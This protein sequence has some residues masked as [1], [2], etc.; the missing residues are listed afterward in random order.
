MYVSRFFLSAVI[1]SV[2]KI[3]LPFFL[4]LFVCCASWMPC[5]SC[6]EFGAT[7]AWAEE[8]LKNLWLDMAT[9]NKKSSC[10]NEYKGKHHLQ[11]TNL[12]GAVPECWGG[13]CWPMP[14]FLVFF[15]L[16]VCINPKKFRN[17]LESLETTPVRNYEVY[18]V[19]LLAYLK[20]HSMHDF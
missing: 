15:S 4:H 3:P 18:S 2:C 1:K 13:C 17:K 16:Q 7:L 10:R 8:K 14:R 19:E 5:M 9:H 20:K 12:K 6:P 11:K